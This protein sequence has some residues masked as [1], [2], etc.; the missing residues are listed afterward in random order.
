MC[1]YFYTLLVENYKLEEHQL[2]WNRFDTLCTD[3]VKQFDWIKVLLNLSKSFYDLGIE[4]YIYIV[5][6]YKN[7]FISSASEY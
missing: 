5:Y 7:V 2:T 1:N 4:L 3:I 6:I